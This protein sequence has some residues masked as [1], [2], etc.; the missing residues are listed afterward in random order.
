MRKNK[1]L[2]IGAAILAIASGYEFFSATRVSAQQATG[3][4]MAQESAPAL[5]TDLPA[6]SNT[7]SVPEPSA[8]PI[9]LNEGAE[10]RQML[11]MTPTVGTEQRTIMDITTEVAIAINGQSQP[12]FEAPG[13]RLVMDSVVTDIDENGLITLEFVYTDVQMIGSPALPPQVVELMRS[14][15][16]SLVGTGGIIVLDAQ[17]ATQS[18][19][20]DVSEDLDP[21]VRASMEQMAQSF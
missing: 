21:T 12:S 14:Q 16:S 2:G 3:L 19:T 18:F 8:D 20:L 6:E 13:T 5:E 10:P 1:M 9:V 15:I 11:R 7:I 17:G 4:E